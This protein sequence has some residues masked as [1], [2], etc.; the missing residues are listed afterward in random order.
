MLQNV[1]IVVKVAERSKNLKG[2][3]V[4]ELKTCSKNLRAAAT[5]VA[6]KTAGTSGRQM[7]EE[8]ERL[9]EKEERDARAKAESKGATEE[10]MMTEEM[11]EEDF[12][13][14]VQDQSPAKPARAKRATRS[15]APTGKALAR[16]KTEKEEKPAEQ[17][18]R[19]D[20]VY[21][22]RVRGKR[23]ALDEPSLDVA[24]EDVRKIIEGVSIRDVTKG[25]P[26]EVRRN[27]QN[28]IIRCEGAMTRIPEDT[29]K[30]KEEAKKGLPVVTNM[31][32]VR[33][34]VRVTAKETAEKVIY[35]AK[36]AR[37]KIPGNQET[38]WVEVARRKKGGKKPETEKKET[39][40]GNPKKPE[41]PVN[42][43]K[44]GEKRRYAEVVKTKPPGNKGDR[45]KQPIPA[46]GGG[47]PEKR[48][49]RTAEKPAKVT[50]AQG[51]KA[52]GPEARK[53]QRRTPR[54]EAVT[55]S[56]P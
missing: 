20:P 43:G 29:S 2:T 17:P 12:P 48:P 55:V 25:D 9:R 3:Y 37:R 23:R 6:R 18:R 4:K 10:V 13:P 44:G 51:G 46:G 42:A 1:D 7:E 24:M 27:L 52:Q 14:R 33:G 34:R 21:R 8:N 39:A 30:G 40:T 50:E 11:P 53:K 19:E 36:T 56:F 31:E 49:Q 54:S 35:D 41:P 15:K 32:V 22:P 5:V 45:A 16:Q 38:P 47:K 28:L 26:Q